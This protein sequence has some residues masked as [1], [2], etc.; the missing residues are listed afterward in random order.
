MKRPEM[1]QSFVPDRFVGV[2]WQHR[3]NLPIAVTRV[4]KQRFVHMQAIISSED[5]IVDNNKYSGDRRTRIEMSTTSKKIGKHHRTYQ[6]RPKLGDESQPT[7]GTNSPKTE[8]HPAHTVS[9]I[10]NVYTPT[11]TGTQLPGLHTEK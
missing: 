2:C 11:Q 3:P 8:A 10:H 5:T 6:N 7:Q 4:S 1:L 9:M